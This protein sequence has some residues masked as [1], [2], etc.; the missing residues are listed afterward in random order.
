MATYC[1]TKSVDEF[2]S[3]FH[4]VETSIEG[5]EACVELGTD[6]TIIDGRC[7]RVEC[8]RSNGFVTASDI[9][10]RKLG[11]VQFPVCVMRNMTTPLYGIVNSM[12]NDV[13]RLPT[14]IWAKVFWIWWVCFPVQTCNSD[15]LTGVN[16]FLDIVVVFILKKWRRLEVLHLHR[17]DG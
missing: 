17:T 8:V 4:P 1:V 10:G 16:A 6:G 13:P 5:I 14:E 11:F 12:L 9:V 3:E 2:L 7:V 15:T